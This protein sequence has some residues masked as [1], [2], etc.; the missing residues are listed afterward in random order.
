MEQVKKGS[1][2]RKMKYG[3]QT[4]AMRIPVSMVE[5]VQDLLDTRAVIEGAFQ[6]SLLPKYVNTLI[7][8][9]SEIMIQPRLLMIES[10]KDALLLRNDHDALR[11]LEDMENDT[12]VELLHYQQSL[13]DKICDICLINIAADDIDNLDILPKLKPN[14]GVL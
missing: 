6:K 14:S 10:I 11:R 1:G 4:V 8:S 3:E 7:D 2:G 5:Q 13:S 9:I 12:K